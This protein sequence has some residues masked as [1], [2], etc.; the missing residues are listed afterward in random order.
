MRYL[1]Q[2]VVMLGDVFIFVAGGYCLWC[3]PFML[4]IVAFALHVWWKQGGF[5]AWKPSNIQEFLKN[6]KR[7]GL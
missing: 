4:P 6:A 3:N 1:L 2:V 5:Y 7:A